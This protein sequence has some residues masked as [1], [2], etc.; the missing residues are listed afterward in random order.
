MEDLEKKIIEVAKLT[1]EDNTHEI[2]AFIA[3][4]KSP[5]ARMYWREEMCSKKEVEHISE[6][7]RLHYQCHVRKHTDINAIMSAEQFLIMYNTQ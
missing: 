3:G 5:E 1:Y 6:L 7:Y 4:A 2:Y